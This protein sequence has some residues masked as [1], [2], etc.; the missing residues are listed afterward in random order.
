MNN[1]ASQA[2]SPLNI[3][4]SLIIKEATIQ[5]Q[6]KILEKIFDPFYTDKNYGTGLG[7]IIC[8]EIINLHDG[9]I[10][11]NSEPNSGTQVFISLP[12]E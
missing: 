5:E 3:S 11:L 12:I 7:L 1:K 6:D 9:T 8:N 10:T 2:K 4:E